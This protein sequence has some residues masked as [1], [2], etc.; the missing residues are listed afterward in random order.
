MLNR[1]RQLWR[2]SNKEPEAIEKL[3]AISRDEVELIPD[4]GDGR[5]EFMTDGNQE[6]YDEF[7]KE[8]T[9][10]NKFYDRLKNL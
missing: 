4:L 2:L 6:E 10:W 3:L 9:G 1:I 5:A 8:R 7:N